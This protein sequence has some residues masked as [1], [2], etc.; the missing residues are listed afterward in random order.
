MNTNQSYTTQTK[1]DTDIDKQQPSFFQTLSNTF[2]S[3]VNAATSKSL[4]PYTSSY[5]EIINLLQKEFDIDPIKAFCGLIL[6]ESLPP[7]IIP[8]IP[9]NK[10]ALFHMDIYR[11]SRHV[12]AA[13]GS[14]H[15]KTYTPINTTE[16]G[17]DNNT[18]FTEEQKDI[19]FVCSRVG[20]FPNMLIQFVNSPPL[21]VASY[22]IAL[23]PTINAIVFSIRGTF[24][25]NDAISDLILY[26]SEF[27]FCGVD[28]IIIT[29]H[30]F[31][32]GVATVISLLLKKLCPKWNIFCYAFAP[33]AS[34]SEELATSEVVKEIVTSV[35]FNYDIVPSLCLTS[36]KELIERINNVLTQTNFDVLKFIAKLLKGKRTDEAAREMMNESGIIL[37]DIRVNIESP[38]P[39]L[40]GGVIYH[41]KRNEENFSL[42]E[43]FSHLFSSIRIAPTMISD[44]LPTNYLVS[45]KKLYEDLTGEK[46]VFDRK[47]YYEMALEQL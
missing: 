35:I 46:I 14:A 7:P 17:D 19:A 11:L 45:S 4:K 5:S 6:L 33:A 32:G 18:T 39:L 10:D 37:K 13:Y 44:H 38:Q 21:F 15:D 1:D 47:Q 40:P 25:V 42:Q 29:G 28:G 3:A 23:D 24:S 31:G 36:C 22:Y 41:I 43:V 20:I 16:L 8:S 34:L 2:N 30:S 26:G 9:A 12:I 27:N